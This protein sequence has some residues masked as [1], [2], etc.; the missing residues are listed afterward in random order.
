MLFI[1]E[2]LR[3]NKTELSKYIII[4]KDY[5]IIIIERLRSKIAILIIYI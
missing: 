2:A 5:L 1:R 4:Y 3:Y